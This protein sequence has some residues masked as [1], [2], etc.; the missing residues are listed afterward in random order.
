MVSSPRNRK[1]KSAD[2][3]DKAGKRRA[4]AAKGRS[5]APTT[6]TCDVCG[7][8]AREIHCRLVCPKCGAMRDCSDP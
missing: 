6:S 1:P 8:E 2:R 7:T 5:E 3:A 4:A